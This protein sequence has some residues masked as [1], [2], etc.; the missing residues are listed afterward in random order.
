MDNI[1]LYADYQLKENM[2]VHGAF[3]YERY[4]SY[5][6][7]LDGVDPATISN[8]L[9]FGEDSPDYKIGV[10]TVTLRYKF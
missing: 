10:V 2:T 6:W 1:K 8:V 5:D 9:S 7:A 3:W 4:N